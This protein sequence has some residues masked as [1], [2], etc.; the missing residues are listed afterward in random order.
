MITDSSSTER[1]NPSKNPW[2]EIVARYQKPSIGRA[3]W[4]VVNTLVPY[5]AL[6]CLM[7]YTLSVSW[8]LTISLA[9]MAG[10]IL[11]RAFIIFHDCGH[12]SFFKS[13]VANHVLGAVTGV[14]TFTPFYHW[15]WEHAIHHSSSGDLDRRG[16][17]DVWTLTV[18][19]YL[20]SSRWRRFAYR[21]ARNPVVLFVLAPLY[22]FLIQQ[23]VP[24]LKAPARERY[25]VYWTN[26][27]LGSMAAGLIAIFGLKAYLIIQ[28]TALITAGSVG[29]WLFYVQHQ[30]EGAYWERTED[31][32]YADAAL[33]GSSFY[34]LPRILQWFSGNIGFHH[35][36]HLSP[37]IPNYNL[38]KCHRTEPL[39][40]GVKPVTLFSSFRS[41]T[42]RL[43]DEQQRKLVGFRHLRTRL[44]TKRPN[45]EQACG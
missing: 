31:W 7:Y 5:A 40:Q 28:L 44:H 8:W 22:L 11:V 19:E 24:S 18:Q 29:V 26:L 23:R 17:G 6:W 43:W 13:A 3:T 25:S 14:L 34:K 16:T 30:F 15:R 4:Q 2:K 36:H 41:L 32:D 38:E 42:F 45:P 20:E 1:E 12:G 10:A 27:A 33:K 39:F 9:V 37:R 21:L 35:I